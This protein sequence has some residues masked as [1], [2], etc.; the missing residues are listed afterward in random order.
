M[1]IDS[2]TVPR[3]VTMACSSLCVDKTLF[4]DTSEG[5][6]VAHSLEPA[7]NWLCEGALLR[8]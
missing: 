5:P 4:A 3:E 2:L 1:L 7:E 6:E 8:P